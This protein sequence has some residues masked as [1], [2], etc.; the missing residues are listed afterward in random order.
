MATTKKR[1]ASK[2]AVSGRTRAGRTARPRATKPRK[3][4]A[5]FPDRIFAVASPHSLGGVSMF[6]PGLTIDASNVGA[7]ESDEELVRR[8]ITRLQDA[9]FEVLQAST[10]TINIAGSRATFE[11]AFST[12]LVPVERETIKSGGKV[13]TTT[14]FDAPETPLFGLIDTA[15][16]GKRGGSLGGV[17]K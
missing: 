12:R 17:N 13:G 3:D 14:C 1:R 16:S 11:R 2:K 6:A 8:S 7:F 4:S 9:G 5:G 15:S 10:R